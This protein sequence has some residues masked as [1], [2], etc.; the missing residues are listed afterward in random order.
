[1]THYLLSVHSVEGEARPPM[2]DEEMQQSHKQVGIIEQ[3]MKSLGAWVFSGRL[4]APDT[5][6]VVRM[7]DGKVLTT[8]GPFAESR[9]HLGGFYIIEAED[10]DAAVAWA[11]KV[12]EAINAPIEVRP[13]AGFAA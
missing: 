11:S 6:T 10:L 1:M 8:D 12:T 2:T 9:E 4:H 3:E 5:A 7:S 13:F